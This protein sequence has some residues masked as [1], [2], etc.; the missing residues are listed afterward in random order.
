MTIEVHYP[1][2]I[3]NFIIVKREIFTP[4]NEPR[5]TIQRWRAVPE[6]CENGAPATEAV[7][8]QW[9]AERI[10]DSLSRLSLRY[11]DLNNKHPLITIQLV[12][13]QKDY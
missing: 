1:S 8:I 7:G 12:R 10:S 6:D 11:C 13:F 2:A 3:W 5:W 9:A 4:N